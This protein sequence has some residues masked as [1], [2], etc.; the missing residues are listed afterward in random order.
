MPLSDVCIQYK[1]T[2]MVAVVYQHSYTDASNRSTTN[3]PVTHSPDPTKIYF[4]P[5]VYIG[6]I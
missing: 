3:W 6:M 4:R 5:Y 2:W 1:D